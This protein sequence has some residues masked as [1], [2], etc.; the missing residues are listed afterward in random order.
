MDLTDFNAFVRQNGSDLARLAFLLCGDRGHAEDLVQS[1][2]LKSHKAWPRIAQMD[3][4]TAYVR[5]ILTREF[6][7]WR[8]RRSSTEV[9]TD[10]ILLRHGE[11]VEDPAEAIAERDATWRHLNALSRR[12]RTVLVL[13]YYVDLS[14]DEI[15]ETLRCSKATVRSHATRGLR[16]LRQSMKPLSQETLT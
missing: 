4:P 15:A 7:S 8:R 6:L 11:S 5:T 2:L 3:H 12:Q 9:V 13:K 10:G 14:D 1:S 16:A